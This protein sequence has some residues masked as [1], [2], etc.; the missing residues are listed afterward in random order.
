M[1]ERE[2]TNGERR[3]RGG[4]SISMRKEKG[5]GALPPLK[6]VAFRARVFFFCIFFS[7]VSKLL[8]P[9]LCMLKTIIYR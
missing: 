6:R 1:V 3:W 4:R 7:S 8:P 9:F 5:R 2:K